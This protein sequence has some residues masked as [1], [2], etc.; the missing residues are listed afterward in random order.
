MMEQ[1]GT[2]RSELFLDRLVQVYNNSG[3][4]HASLAEEA[5]VSRN[6]VQRLLSNRN[7]IHVIKTLIDISSALGVTMKTLFDYGEMLPSSSSVG[8]KSIDAM[9]AECYN[10]ESA[11]GMDG[12]TAYAHDDYTVHND[13]FAKRVSERYAEARR[14][15]GGLSL[16]TERTINA[17]NSAVNGSWVKRHLHKHYF[18][19]GLLIVIYMQVNYVK[20]SPNVA[21]ARKVIDHIVLEHDKKAYAQ[22]GNLR[23]KI[24]KRHW[25]HLL[26]APNENSS[27]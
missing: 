19:E 11:L 12:F 6:T 24:M 9:V 15:G 13:S 2:H 21:T 22:D 25:A 7:N 26:F 17:Q 8:I 27:Q 3:H 1:D 14:N 4:T 18:F 16:E 5:G 20:N 10:E 23:P